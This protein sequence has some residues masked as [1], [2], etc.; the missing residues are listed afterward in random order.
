[1]C[2]LCV[3]GLDM[4]SYVNDVEHQIY[5]PLSLCDRVLN[6]VLLKEQK[7]GKLA[8]D[9]DGICV[10]CV[11]LCECVLWMC[12][13]VCMDSPLAFF[14]FSRTSLIQQEWKSFLRTVHR[15]QNEMERK[16]LRGG[17][18]SSV[19]GAGGEYSIFNFFFQD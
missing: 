13:F 7:A 12:V 9:A 10:R 15:R 3:C 18:G 4:S 14:Q 11:S 1:M 17:G 8:V 6:N 5:L 19:V 2:V 16:T